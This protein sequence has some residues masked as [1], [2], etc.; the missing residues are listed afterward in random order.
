MN[1]RRGSRIARTGVVAG[2]V[3]E[4][5]PPSNSA[6]LAEEVAGTQDA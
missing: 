6:H 1:A 3:A 4:R 5:G 2:I